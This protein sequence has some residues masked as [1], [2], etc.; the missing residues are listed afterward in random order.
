MNKEQLLESLDGFI[1]DYLITA[2]WSSTD[3][4]DRPLEDNYTISDLS[5]LALLQAIA[6]CQQFQDNNIHLIHYDLTRAAHD[7]WLTRNRH[8]VGFWDG[9]WPE[10]AGKILTESS[11]KF[12]GI[13]LYVGDDGQIHSLTEYKMEKIG[14]EEHSN[15]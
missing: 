9:D 11:H 10:T 7:F 15:A 4:N 5:E 1:R 12:G 14:E 13:D 6:D 8:G 2:M 3:D